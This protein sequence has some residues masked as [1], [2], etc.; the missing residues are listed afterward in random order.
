[1]MASSM[2]RLLNVAGRNEETELSLSR[3]VSWALVILVRLECRGVVCRMGSRLLNTAGP[4][5]VGV[6]SKQMTEFLIW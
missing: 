4:D 5:C 1:M 2:L 6:K 3:D